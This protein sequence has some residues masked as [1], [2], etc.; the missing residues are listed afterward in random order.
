MWVLATPLGYV[1]QFEPYQGTKGRKALVAGLRMGGSVVIDLISELQELYSYHLTFDNLFTSLPLVDCLTS[2]G[3]ACTGTI[4][5]N[6][7]ED[8]PLKP[9]KEMEKTTRGT[10]DFATDSKN[11]LTVVRWNDNNVVN[12]V[13]NKVGLHPI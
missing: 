12:T 4:R 10:Y 9:V 8:C 7:I 2:K 3:I 11:G 1:M 6:R 13:S 5:A